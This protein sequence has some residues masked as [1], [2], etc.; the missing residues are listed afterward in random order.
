ME[1]ES[2]QK[3][4]VLPLALHKLK[5]DESARVAPLAW[6]AESRNVINNHRIFE[7]GLKQNDWT[8]GKP[9]SSKCHT[10]MHHTP[11]SA[12]KSSADRPPIAV[13]FRFS[14]EGPQDRFLILILC[15][16]K[17]SVFW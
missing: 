9:L 14:L 16:F 4:T 5:L 6:R 10:T 12:R 2:W 7:I 3:H 15:T 8:K 11:T 13:N 1:R 17:H